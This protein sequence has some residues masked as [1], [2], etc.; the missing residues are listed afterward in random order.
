MLNFLPPKILGSLGVLLL[1]SNLLLWLI[2]YLAV[3]FAKL[4]IPNPTWRRWCTNVLTWIGWRWAGLDNVFMD[5]L[6]KIEW[7]VSGVEELD[8][9]DRYIVISNHRSWLDIPVLLR[10]FYG[11][12]AFPRFFMKQQLLW[13]PIIGMAAWALDMPFMKRYS[14]EYLAQH[15]ELRGKDLETTRRACERLRDLPISFMIF[16]EGTRFTPE[17]HAR[18]ESPYQHLLRPKAGG[19]AYILSALGD[20]FDTLIDVIVVY[21]D[22]DTS[23]WNFLSGRLSQIIVRVEKTSIPHKYIH[24]DYVD[25]PAFREEF[26]TWLRELWQAKDARIEQVLQEARATVTAAE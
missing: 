20:K 15:P 9:R 22:E 5:L 24:G 14:R 7:E 25:D 26:Q 13:V 16:V 10:A 23:F 3:T 19:L 21:P 11:H 18:Q 6:Y 12:L 17:K 1:V 2:P 4:L 8:R